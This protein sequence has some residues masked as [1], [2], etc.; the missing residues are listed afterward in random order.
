MPE[1]RHYKDRLLLLDWRLKWQCDLYI[2]EKRRIVHHHLD[3]QRLHRLRVHL[4]NGGS[5][6]G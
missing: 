2:D 6:E 1:N 3:P 4:G 5:V